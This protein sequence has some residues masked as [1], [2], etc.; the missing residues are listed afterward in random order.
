M[1][2]L[3]SIIIPI[4]NLEKYIENCLNS[5]L[6]QTYKNLEIICVDDGSND[7]S[8]EIVKK[9]ADL[10]K[11]I[12]Y[13]YRENSGVSAARNFGLQIAS[14]DYIMFVDGDDYLHYQ[15]A[16]I[17][18]KEITA[19]HCDMVCANELYTAD[20][21]EEMSEIGNYKSRDI[22]VEELFNYKSNRCPGKSVWGKIIKSEI[23]KCSS[24]PLGISNGEDG[25]Y[26]IMLLDR[27]IKVRT[28]EAV[29]YYYLN[30]ENSAV[31]SK[32]TLSKFSIT[33]SF[34]ILCEHLRN[35]SNRFL[36]KYCLQY[37]YQTIFYNR[38]R[39]IGTDCEKTVLEGSKRIGKKWLPDF[40]SNKDISPLIKILFTVF[41]Y[42]RH[43]Y[44][45]ARGIQD[46]TMFDFYR[47]RRKG[48]ADSGVKT[49]R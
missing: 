4:Y 6:N 26:I 18:L 13:V 16:E 32:F 19:S 37:L 30:R 24:F 47:N 25:Y 41:F 45:L 5:V 38:T 48:S 39:A 2:S 11:R 22:S 43:I 20:M 31:T 1:D 21:H 34:D 40:L 49:Q 27:G 36:K 12:N 23:A 46:P 29:L 3:I 28:V 42:S 9:Y 8:A 10:D 15:A 7:N 35:S 44:E 14:G 17:F 33:Y